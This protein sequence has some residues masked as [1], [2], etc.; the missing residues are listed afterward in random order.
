MDTDFSLADNPHRLGECATHPRVRPDKRL[1]VSFF[2]AGPG[3]QRRRFV[4][5]TRSN[6]PSSASN[7]CF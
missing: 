2:L 7:C 5:D 6:A 1:A 3:P 4:P